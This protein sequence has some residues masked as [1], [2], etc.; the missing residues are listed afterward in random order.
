MSFDYALAALAPIPVD[1]GV[2]EP[3]ERKIN[4]ATLVRFERDAR[5]MSLIGSFIDMTGASASRIIAEAL[6]D[7][8]LSQWARD[9][10]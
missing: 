8:S 7:E 1:G 6:E 10:L 4:T 3:D 5:T 9:A 2:K